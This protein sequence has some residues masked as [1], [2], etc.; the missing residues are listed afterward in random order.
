MIKKFVYTAFLVFTAAS[1]PA[2]G[3]P[4]D[5]VFPGIS[6][7]QRAEAF[8][9]GGYLYSGTAAKSLTIVP[10]TGGNITVNKRSLGEN[11]GFFVEA[12]RVI[13]R[14]NITLLS[15][16][17][18]LERIGD[19]K[20]HLYHSATKDRYVPLF[21]GSV[22]IEGPRK[23]RTLLPDPPTASIL[24]SMETIYVRLTDANFGNCYYEISFT[25]NLRGILYRIQNFRTVTFGP[26]PVM[27]ERTFT[28]LLYIEPVE[29][30]LAVYCLAGAEVSN[31]IAKHVDIP[32]ALNK[33][34]DVIIAWML[35]GIR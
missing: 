2:Q 10:R 33:R 12:L 30:G 25:T 8:S 6:A 35:A 22:R 9:S 18:S 20:K 23:I 11:P 34:M 31:F 13:P 1:L 21:E 24:P 16:Y 27:R 4:F 17:N 28:A 19:L 14:K 32:S 5:Q 7:G 3:R 29:E 15:I 26:I